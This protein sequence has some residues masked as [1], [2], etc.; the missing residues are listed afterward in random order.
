MGSV[1]ED[2]KS[3]LGLILQ[4]QIGFVKG[5]S[6]LFTKTAQDPLCH[7]IIYESIRHNMI[8]T[9]PA[10]TTSYTIDGA[11][12]GPNGRTVRCAACKHTWHAQKVDDPIELDLGARQKEAELEAQAAEEAIK[13]REL[14]KLYRNML[15]DKKRSQALITQIMVWGGIAASFIALL[16]AAYVMRVDVVRAFPSTAKA[17]AMIGA[18]VNATGLEPVSI[19]AAP[20]LAEGRF[21]VHVTAQYRNIRNEPVPVPPIRARVL[22]AEGHEVIETLIPSQG[23]M[24]DAHATRDISFDVPDPKNLTSKLDLSFDLVAMK[25]EE[26]TKSYAHLYEHAKAREASK[27]EAEAEAE[28]QAVMEKTST[29]PH[30]ETATPPALRDSHSEAAASEPAQEPAHDTA[31]H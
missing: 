9:C 25:A 14:P 23:I 18:H 19:K 20:G 27:A 31:H 21:V 22:D 16:G 8:L 13:A 4:A 1:I 11:N 2:Y 15:E 26:K 5:F 3:D 29:E 7:S 6:A 30:F 12:L 24:I 10:C 28:H 17:Y